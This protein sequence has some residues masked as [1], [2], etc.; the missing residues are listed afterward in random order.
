MYCSEFLFTFIAP[1][2]IHQLSY[3]SS[4]IITTSFPTTI[5]TQQ[6][7]LGASAFAIDEE[8]A[9]IHKAKSVSLT[10]LAKDVTVFKREIE[11]CQRM[12][13]AATAEWTVRSKI[14]IADDLSVL[15]R[16]QAAT[17][18]AGGCSSDGSDYTPTAFAMIATELSSIES[19]YFSL[20]SA[21][22]GAK[23]KGISM[24]RF[25]GEEASIATVGSVFTVLA[26]FLSL[27]SQS[28]QK[29]LAKLK[30]QN[31][32]QK[33]TTK[34]LGG[35]SAVDSLCSPLKTIRRG[36]SSHGGSGTTISV[37]KGPGKSA[38]KSSSTPTRSPV[39]SIAHKLSK[40]P[41]QHH[42][43]MNSSKSPL[44]LALEAVSRIAMTA[45]STPKS[46]SRTLSPKAALNTKTAIVN[47]NIPNVDDA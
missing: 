23:E 6:D 30:K 13:D 11:N 9:I 31:A 20:E 3:L 2:I 32:Q 37:L 28:K 5:A 44:A 42:G 14:G 25:F 4:P 41:S 17:S 10:E 34:S 36:R 39:P 7:A 12:L 33:A 40:S 21:I 26:D 8:L 18:A 47:E 46:Q 29:Y 22:E 24:A 35:S 19:L 45:T 43:G 38:G 1:I 27:F 15:P 16:S